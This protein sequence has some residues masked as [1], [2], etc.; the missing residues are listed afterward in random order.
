VSVEER[1]PLTWAFCR[2]GR[3]MLSASQSLATCDG[4]HIKE[5]MKWLK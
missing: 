2:S 5:H 3:G 4:S 1:T